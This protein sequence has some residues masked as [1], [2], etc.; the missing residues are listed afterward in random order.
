MG[1][2]MKEKQAWTGEIA[3]RYR[4]SGK[5]EKTRILDGFVQATGYNRKYAP[6][7]LTRWG[8][9]TFLL[10]NGKPVRLKAV[11]TGKAKRR[12][13]GGRKPVYGPEV[14]SALRQVW[15]F[16][17][18]QCGK[19]LAPLMREQ[20]PFIAAWTAFGITAEIREKLMAISPATIDRALKEDRKKLTVRGI[21]D[22]KPGKLLKNISRSEPITPGTSGNREQVCLGFSGLTPSITAEPGIPAGLRTLS[23]T[24]PLPPPMSLPDGCGL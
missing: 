12:K 13:G 4:R 9:E 10:V 17:R 15:A 22:T 2:N 16:F 1:L 11:P 5:K 6:H 18:F 14:I 20:M 21:S 8:K 24:S 7:I 3:P 19:L 23:P